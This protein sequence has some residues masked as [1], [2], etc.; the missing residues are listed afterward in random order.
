MVMKC[1]RCQ[2]EFKYESL[3]TR[4]LARKKQCEKVEIT[5]CE[6]KCKYCKR[7]L[8]SNQSRNRHES[9][10]KYK[11]DFVRNLELELDIEVDYEYSNTTCRFCDKSMHPNNLLR[12]ESACKEKEV[13]KTKLQN[14]LKAHS[15][16]QGNTT[17][18][19]NT[20]NHNGDNNTINITLRP[21]GSENLDYITPSKIL[22]LMKLGKCQF[23][24]EAEKQRFLRLMYKFI[25]GNPEYPENHNMLIPS[26]KGS[27][28]LVYTED[29]FEHIHRKLA[30]NQ[31]LTTISDVS[32]NNLALQHEDD[33]EEKQR[34]ICKSKY[35]R[36]VNQYIEGSD[37]YDDESDQRKNA[38]NRNT[39]AQ[40]S[41]NCKDVIKETHKK[42]E[43]HTQLQVISCE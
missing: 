41:Y 40:T 38:Q 20:Y 26:L 21:F 4:H 35:E 23:T 42:L 9:S 8:S 24:G 7:P 34:Q 19:N 12:H 43:I 37:T 33:E 31:V 27:N 11:D 1:E 10:C 29:G 32:Y 3:L 17:I 5:K 16:K 36:F 30:E 28:A 2:M 14:M 18:N 25:H 39:I 15:A 6:H 13:Y 22:R